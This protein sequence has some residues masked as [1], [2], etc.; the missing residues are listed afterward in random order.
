[1]EIMRDLQRLVIISAACGAKNAR[2]LI[3]SLGSKRSKM[4]RFRSAHIMRAEFTPPTFSAIRRLSMMQ[5]IL[6]YALVNIFLLV[7]AASCSQKATEPV[8]TPT[9]AVPGYSLGNPAEFGETLNWHGIMDVTVWGFIENAN[10]LIADA[11][12]RIDP[13]DAGKKYVIL[14]IT[15]DCTWDV[16][17]KACSP[18]LAFSL[19]SPIGTKYNEIPFLFFKKKI[20]LVRD[21]ENQ[22]L[23]DLRMFSGLE[24][25]EF[26]VGETD[27]GG[28]VYMID[29][30][31]TDLIVSYS[32][33][34][35][36]ELPLP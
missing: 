14:A 25:Y 11:G 12:R 5:K 6:T 36:W 29:E 30:T 27:S 18:I 33:D 26:T 15:F 17:D 19:N 22:D 1:M 21:L 16:E 7:F 28:L 13:P 23:E 2:R 20:A 9:S 31:E 8:P 3:I 10:N 35:F 32:D 34:L 4:A 24:E